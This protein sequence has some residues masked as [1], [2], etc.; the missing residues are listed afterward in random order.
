MAC[1]PG[2]NII[3]IGIKQATNLA[4]IQLLHLPIIHAKINSAM[5]WDYINTVPY[6]LWPVSSLKLQLQYETKMY[7]IMFYLFIYHK[8]PIIT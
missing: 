6:N 2:L 7:I 1:C 3:W 8:L 5:L 4:Y